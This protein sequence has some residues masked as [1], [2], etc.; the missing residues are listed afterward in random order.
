MENNSI[1]FKLNSKQTT[2]SG[3]PERP[4]LAFLRQD[5]RIKS[6]K[7]GCSGQA[8]CG[9]CMVE[10]DGKAVLS[11]VTKMSKLAGASVVTIEGF[12]DKL[13]DFLA[14]AF[15]AKGAVQ[16]GFCS[17]G[18]LTR[19]K[20]LLENNPTPSRDEVIMALKFNVCRC[21]GYLNIVDAIL[22]ASELLRK[23]KPIRLDQ[24]AV[25][26]AAHPKYRAYGKALGDNP[27]VDDLDFPDMLHGALKFSDHPRARI[28]AIDISAAVKSDG[29]RR[30]VLA[31]DIPGERMT[32]LIR[33]D[34]PLMI[35]EGE[36]TRYIGDVLATVVAD[37][38]ADARRAVALIKVSYEVLEPLTDMHEAEDS[39]VKIHPG[40]NLLE[41]TVVKRGEDIERILASSA[42]IAEG[43]IETQRV[44]HAFLETE[45]AIARYVEGV[46]ELYSQGQGV[47]VDRAAISRILDLPEKQV[48]VTLVPNGGGFGGKE[49]LSVQGH[50]SLCAYLLKSSVKIHLSRNESIRMHPKRHPFHMEYRV[51]CDSAGK[52]TGIRARIKGDTG[53][54]ASVGMKVLER[55]AGHA[56]GAYHV[57]NVDINAKTIYTN[58]IP[59]GAMRGFG[60]NQVT[61]ALESC[62]DDLCRQ[63]GFD[64][65][66]FRYDNAL[67]EGSMTATGQVLKAAVGVRKTLLA[68]KDHYSS[69]RYS[70]IA[71][72]IKNCG[73]GNGMS[74]FSEVR[75]DVVSEQKVLIHHGWTEMG[76]GVNTVAVQT[77]HQETGIDPA[78]IKVIVKTENEALSGMTTSSRGTSLLG[79]A[80]IAASKQ[81][82]DDL[83]NYTLKQL[84]GKSYAGRWSFDDSTKPG[85]PGEIITHY[86]YSYAS[87]LAIIDEN[88]RLDK[89]VA[90]H[91]A[92]RIINKVLF[93]GQIHGAV[94]MGLG[95]TFTEELPMEKGF[96]KG[97]GFRDLGIL[98]IKQM[99]DVEVIA[100]EDRDPLGPY[101]AKGVGEIGLVPT[102][103]AVCN[104]LTDF[105]GIR[106][107][108]LPL[109]PRKK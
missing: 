50:A 51:G 62:L 106:R 21:T 103:A 97:M 75:I 43:V 42:Y 55:A 44:E 35:C 3:D 41:E 22:H 82:K 85:A 15:I 11:C 83:E 52:L 88:G 93:E 40:G 86:S 76:Q 96:P 49:D 39:P 89:I 91:D 34:W 33:N 58:N 90:A 10:V 27:F 59:C 47:Y 32:G 28:N 77:L 60:V 18:F 25:I 9:A 79:N 13:K 98:P 30:I 45:T 4:L 101:G 92:G 12:P 65:W 23:N 64:R 56:S 109:N 63:G 37:S 68:I 69:A 48:K 8:A 31:N 74:D 16:C 84:S 94:H 7:D 72:G 24:T 108:K 54:Y 6:P 73:V 71:C 20:I 1:H 38:E 61:F 107:F 5:R 66:Q 67:V 95:Y 57:P 46:L 81:L 19:T 104:G 17:P 100:V 102:A 99:P 70:G 2:Y 80:V 29:V 26:G 105:D 78:V 87:Q 36:T 53:A 14:K